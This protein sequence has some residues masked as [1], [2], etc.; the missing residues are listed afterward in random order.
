MQRNERYWTQFVDYLSQQGSQLQT[1]EAYNKSY[2]NF[3][4]GTGFVVRAI[5]RKKKIS[6]KFVMRGV[7]AT[8]YFDSLREDPAINTAFGGQLIWRGPEELEKAWASVS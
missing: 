3:R 1:G 5:A 4:I 8:D 6:V 7:R 2:L